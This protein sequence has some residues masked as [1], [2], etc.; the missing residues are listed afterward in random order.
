MRLKRNFKK[1]EDQ[2][3]SPILRCTILVL[4]LAAMQ[5]AASAQDGPGL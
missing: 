4:G 5:T 1:G 2:M 3:K